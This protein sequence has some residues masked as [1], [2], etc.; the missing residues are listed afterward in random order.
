[1]RL[2]NVY[3]I[4]PKDAELHATGYF[5]CMDALQQEAIDSTA[6]IFKA[7]AAPERLKLRMKCLV[8]HHQAEIGAGDSFELVVGVTHSSR[9]AEM[10]G[11]L[12]AECAALLRNMKNER[13]AALYQKPVLHENKS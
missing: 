10:M 2:A 3:Y 6:H 5:F 11:I 1:M 7:M 9:G 12:C 13:V 8:C 4:S